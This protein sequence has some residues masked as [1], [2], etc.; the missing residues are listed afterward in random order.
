MTNKPKIW[1][2]LFV[3]SWSACKKGPS[4]P[5]L[6][7]SKGG[8]SE[9]IPKGV[10]TDGDGVPDRAAPVTALAF[11]TALPRI[12]HLQWENSVKDVLLLPAIPNL[13]S[14]FT[15]DPSGSFFKSDGNLL[16]VT[17]AL[18]NDYQ[19]AAETVAAKTIGDPTLLN[20]LVP[21]GTPESG[22]ARAKAIIRPLA[23]RAFRGN[24]TEAQVNRLVA[25]Y[26]KGP[27]L[28]GLKNA[29]AAG[30]QLVIT[31][32]LQSPRFL[33]R[34]E[35]G[36]SPSQLV[37]LTAHE[38][39]SRL[40]FAAWNTIP[41][42]ELLKAAESGELLS[43]TGLKAQVTR[44]LADARSDPTLVDFF[45][46]IFDTESF[47]DVKKDAKALGYWPGDM[48][49]TLVKEA[50]LFINDVII[51]EKGG[52]NQLLTA[53]YAFV[54]AKTAPLYGIQEKLGNDF[55]K[56][57]LNPEQRSGILTQ[58]GFLA[59]R[60]KEAESDP[61]HRG[62]VVAT[63]VL[64]AELSAPPAT[65]PPLPDIAPGLSTRDRVEQHTGKGT[66]GSTCHGDVINPAGYAFENFD[67]A[68]RWRTMDN[69]K[70]VN[71]AGR[72]G[73][74]AS[75]ISFT[76]A[77]DFNKAIANRDELHRCYVAKAIE[78]MY[79]RQVDPQDESLIAVL[80]KRS[81]KNLSA[82]DL[83]FQLLTDSRI[84]ARGNPEGE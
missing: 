11:T 20:K 79:A 71:A 84:A 38:V 21:D 66:C 59:R 30:L 25:L 41:D 81:A 58:V 22:D 60:S 50:D 32:L 33:Y 75:S 83:F 42:E 73:F 40:S 35:I 18:W 55:V 28:T 13:S 36:K 7:A 63:N 3:L 6:E 17:P 56:K 72:F 2:V 31:A 68:G 9:P 48:G 19:T 51:T 46:K 4:R 70:P 69:D 34:T 74:P 23:R 16:K 1:C 24:V 29:T 64:C 65:F 45:K 26:N 53:P 78:L 37:E 14:S 12:T 80:A 76:N 47:I 5:Y 67:A 27:E 44:L 54:N 61:I 8:S 39:A 82:R 62:V 57:E 77:V 49:L 43:P 52:M 15:A 10:D